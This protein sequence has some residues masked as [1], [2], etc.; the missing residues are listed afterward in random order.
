MTIVLRVGSLDLFDAKLRACFHEFR[1]D[2]L[3]DIQLSEDIVH[4]P[5]SY[6]NKSNFKPVLNLSSLNTL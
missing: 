3:T 5:K 4:S 1:T 2:T 6:S